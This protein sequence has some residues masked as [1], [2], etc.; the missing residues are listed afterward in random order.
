MDYRKSDIKDHSREGARRGTLQFGSKR[1]RVRGMMEMQKG[2]SIK[3]SE[4]FCHPEI[5]EARQPAK[6]LS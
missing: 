4:C 5:K 3:V 1:C 6:H 2:L